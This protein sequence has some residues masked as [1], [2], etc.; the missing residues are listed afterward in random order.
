[1][2]EFDI[3][4]I[5]TA[6]IYVDRMMNG[7]NPATNQPV[8]NEILDNPNVIRCLNFVAEVLQAV[9]E[10]NGLVGNNKSAS[11]KRGRYFT[12]EDLKHFQYRGDASIMQII[13]QLKEPFEGQKVRGLDAP[14]INQYLAEQGYL[15]RASSGLDRRRYWI[16]TAKGEEAGLYTVQREFDGNRYDQIIYSKEGQDFLL[17]QLETIL[18]E[19]RRKTDSGYPH[20]DDITMQDAEREQRIEEGWLRLAEQIRE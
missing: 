8:Q 16:P 19:N 3:Q 14:K 5:L 9:E 18:N 1:M 4:R 2:K 7:R 17:R 10:N 20:A 12:A 6:R 15:A 11:E 13:K